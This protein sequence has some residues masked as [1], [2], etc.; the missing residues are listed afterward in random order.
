MSELS[1]ALRLDEKP[2]NTDLSHPKFGR[3]DRARMQP[4]VVIPR[5][6]DQWTA[7]GIY[8]VFSSSGK[9][10]VV[11][12]DKGEC[13]CKDMEFNRPAE[14]CKHLQRVR[15]MLT[16]TSLPGYEPETNVGQSLAKYLETYL[17]AQMAALSG[18]T[19]GL[20]AELDA[21][22]MLKAE[23]TLND[24]VVANHE[25]HLEDA[26]ETAQHLRD[27]VETILE[28]WRTADPAE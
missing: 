25:S 2:A 13:N 20:K 1:D 26:L 10:Y 5:H 27:P 15:L 28:A 21:L 12:P 18:R 7:I 24:D 22:E 11:A 16:N 9:R 14:G 4:M 6:D 3:S 23:E 19:G 17:T 8:D